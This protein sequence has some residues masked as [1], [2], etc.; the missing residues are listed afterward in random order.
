MSFFSIDYFKD[1]SGVKP[2]QS[3]KLEHNPELQQINDK[4]FNFEKIS[5][6]DKEVITKFFEYIEFIIPFNRREMENYINIQKRIAVKDKNLLIK[7]KQK[8]LPYRPSKVIMNTTLGDSSKRSLL[9]KNTSSNKLPI[10]EKTSIKSAVGSKVS[11]NKVVK[12]D[13]KDNKDG[14]DSKTP[15]R[16]S[17]DSKGKNDKNDKSDKNV[18]PNKS[19]IDSKGDNKSVSPSPIKGTIDSKG[20]NVGSNNNTGN[21][22]INNKVSSNS[23]NNTNANNQNLNKS[24]I[25]NNNLNNSQ[26][27]NNN[28]NNNSNNPS[29]KESNLNANRKQTNES[30]NEIIRKPTGN[31]S[32]K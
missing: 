15:K 23:V 18:S 19:V 31:N 9:K 24:N 26:I 17:I 6:Y 21:N 22:S 32:N 8:E 4:R 10:S 3:K 27:S 7:D 13:G 29:R 12:F 5:Y 28:S 25:N 20:K 11:D 1:L 30:K 16:S 2:S 14:K